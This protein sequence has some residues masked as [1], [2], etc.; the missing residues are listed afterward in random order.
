MDDCEAMDMIDKLNEE[1]DQTFKEN[2]DLRKVNNM[3]MKKLKSSMEMT[4]S[5][6]NKNYK[7]RR[8]YQESLNTIE[9]KETIFKYENSYLENVIVDM[10]GVVEGVV[11]G[12][13]NSTKYITDRNFY[14][15]LCERNTNL[16]NI[17]N[18]WKEDEDKEILI[19]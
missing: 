4:E 18:S 19:S 16:V 3:L 11:E 6:K 15:N 10:G 1:H 8:H 13:T 12:Y 14:D 17:I 2:A 5:L 7:I 9:Y